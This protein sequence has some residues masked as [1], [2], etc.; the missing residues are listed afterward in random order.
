MH[1]LLALLLP[2]LLQGCASLIATVDNKPGD[3]V[4]AG[5]RFD[6]ELICEIGASPAGILGLFSLADLPFSLALDTVLLPYTVPD[7]L[8]QRLR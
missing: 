1:R 5:T 4:Y 3:K 2:L 6:A 8:I 7:A